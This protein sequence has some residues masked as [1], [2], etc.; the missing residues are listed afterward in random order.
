MLIYLQEIQCENE[1]FLLNLP[2]E[3]GFN[4]DDN[5]YYNQWNTNKLEEREI[6]NE[7]FIMPNFDNENNFDNNFQDPSST[8][9][10]LLKI[11]GFKNKNKEIRLF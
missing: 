10:N 9:S 7:F 8:V 4:F 3:N 2:N 6:L 1:E 5:V 11:F